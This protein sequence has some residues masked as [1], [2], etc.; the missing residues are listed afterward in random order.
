MN[1]FYKANKDLWNMRTKEH[2]LGSFYKHNE[3]LE[4]L[5]SLTEIELED[6]KDVKGKSLLHL[7][8]HFGQDTIS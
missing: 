1:E 7:Q 3:F 6:L 5:N 2:L 8:C 4:N